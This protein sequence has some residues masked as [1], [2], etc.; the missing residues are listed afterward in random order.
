[1]KPSFSV[2]L[3]ARQEEKTLPRLL[4]SLE[5][6]KSRGGNVLLLDTGSTDNTVRVAR[7]WGCKVTEVGERFITTIDAD[8]ANKI[9]ARFVIDEEEPI[10][11]AGNRTFHF[12]NA[13]NF[14]ASLSSTDFI[15]MPDC[16]EEFTKLDLEAIERAIADGAERLE[17]EFVFSHQADGSP[18]LRFKH[19]KAYDRRKFSWRGRIHEVLSGTGKTTYLP[20]SQVLLEHWQQPAEHRA[21]YLVGLAL[22]CYEGTGAGESP[23]RA[24]HYLSREMMYHGRH[25]SAIKG[26]EEHIKMNC[27]PTEASQSQLFIGDC[28][29]ALK[30]D[31]EAIEAY[32]KAFNMEGGR[33]EPLIRLAEYYRGKDDF[34]RVACYAAA[35]LQIPQGNF[36]ANDSAHYTHVPHELLYW[37]YWYLGDKEKSKEHF[38]KAFAY[39]PQ[40]PKYV[41]DRRFYYENDPANILMKWTSMIKESRPFTFV[42]FGDGEMI[43]MMDIGHL[44]GNKNCDGCHYFPELKEGLLRSYKKLLPQ[45]N[46]YLGTTFEIPGPNLPFQQEIR[47]DYVKYL[48]WMNGFKN[49][50][51]A[52]VILNRPECLT[53]ELRDFYL[54]IAKSPRRKLYVGPASMKMA[55]EFLGAEFL[56]IPEKDA[57]LSYSQILADIKTKNSEIVLVSAGMMAKCL[58][59]DLE[60]GTFIDIGSG[61][62]PLLGRSTRTSQAP[63]KTLYS[64][65]KERYDEIL[66]TVSFIIPHLSMGNPV[67][68]EGLVKCIESIKQLDYP[69]HKIDLIVLDGPETVPEKVKMGLNQVKG[70][71]ITYAANDVEFASDSLLQAIVAAQREGK[72]LVSFN[73]GP[74]LPDNGNIC[75]HFII[76][77]DLMP[78][79]GGEI[80]C[81]RMTHCGVD[82]LLWAKCDKLKEAFY[83]KDALVVHKHFSKG[84]QYDDVYRRGWENAEKDR[85]ILKEELA[86]LYA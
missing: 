50:I 76:N 16:D 80:F 52:N 61:L 55:A 18:A 59:A 51:S 4:K 30:Q 31:K 35:A 44:N 1:M 69:S 83:C 68:E 54:T 12:A 27:W 73:E 15:W 65:Y 40:S 10:V 43:S 8:L 28:Y 25:K 86:K 13:R 14:A 75:T 63:L 56:E 81:T 45:D 62:D 36:Y 84:S 26:F 67:R 41:F 48:S 5:E 6:F 53:P 57:F 11:K 32:Q 85:A 17:Y 60:G 49:K 77:R 33:R 2:V 47:S 23:D 70:Q 7:D 38:D 39:Q 29:K 34:Q 82:N 3:I 64:F 74:L 71:W 58:A 46:V 79:I 66:P 22:A 20:E 72:G 24:L 78:K 37:A 9:N 42:K 19:S 21:N